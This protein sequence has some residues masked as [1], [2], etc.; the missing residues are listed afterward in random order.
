MTLK[1]TVL[2]A[3]IQTKHPQCT[4]VEPGEYT[5]LTVS[6]ASRRTVVLVVTVTS[7]THCPCVQECSRQQDTPHDTALHWDWNV[8]SVLVLKTQLVTSTGNVRYRIILACS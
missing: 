5:Q 1:H 8:H 7:N 4:K 2:N 6:G 3:D